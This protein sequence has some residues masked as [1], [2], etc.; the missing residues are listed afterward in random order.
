MMPSMTIPSATLPPRTGEPPSSGG[1]DSDAGPAFG[2]LLQRAQGEPR[3]TRANAP[4]GHERK[5]GDAKAQPERHAK[6]AHG[7]GDDA[8]PRSADGAADTVAGVASDGAVAADAAPRS[9][10]TDAAAAGTPPAFAPDAAPRP[11]CQHGA[12]VQTEDGDAPELAIDGRRSARRVAP[13]AASEWRGAAAGRAAAA[14]DAAGSRDAAAAA[15]PL[16]AALARAGEDPGSAAAAGATRAPSFERTTIDATPSALAAGAPLRESTALAPT[17]E[18]DTRLP[19]AALHAAIDEP[20]FGAAVGHQV[21]L[22]VRDGVQEARLQLHPAELGPVTVQI[23]L[24]GQAAHVDFTA[25]VAATRESI[26]QS[27]PALAAALRES[28]FTLAGGGVSSGAGQRGTAAPRDGKDSREAGNRSRVEGSVDGSP[29]L[30]A[31]AQRWTRSLVDVY[32]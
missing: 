2:Q 4:H 28:G 5:A 11:G 26:E 18:A 20:G 6:A 3:P 24:D 25:A 31:P 19:Q 14:A 22:W 7:A 32:A 30:A 9:D 29:A 15:Q 10:A 12:G 21:A 16:R 23:A 1:A 13:H 27:L 17:R 8:P